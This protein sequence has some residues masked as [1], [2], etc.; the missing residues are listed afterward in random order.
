[1][2]SMFFETIFLYL[3]GHLTLGT[4]KGSL[5]CR[6]SSLA[7]ETAHRRKIFW[8]FRERKQFCNSSGICFFFLV[9][10]TEA[11]YQ[12]FSDPGKLID[13]S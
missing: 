7:K 4:Q 5:D 1:M 10:S 6:E 13:F 2:R 8:K 9:I 3:K 12:E 11:E